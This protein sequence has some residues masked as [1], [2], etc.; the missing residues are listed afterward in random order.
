MDLPSAIMIFIVMSIALSISYNELRMGYFPVS[1]KDAGPRHVGIVHSSGGGGDINYIDLPED[2]LME[3]LY[4]DY[5]VFH[6]WGEPCINA[7]DP[8]HVAE[9]RYL[10]RRGRVKTIGY[11]TKDKV[12]FDGTTYWFPEV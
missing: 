3:N 8:S 7:Q 2:K 4:E 5:M 12:V 11:I 6:N 9:Y 10:T 1:K